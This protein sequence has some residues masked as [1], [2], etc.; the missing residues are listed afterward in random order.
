[1]DGKV[2]HFLAGK[3][4]GL[5]AVPAV[6]IRKG[7]ATE[8]FNSLFEQ[9]RRD[10]LDRVTMFAVLTKVMTAYYGLEK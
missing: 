1:M 8:A 10:D 3:R 2:Y 4:S 9:G 7:H 5:V 6:D